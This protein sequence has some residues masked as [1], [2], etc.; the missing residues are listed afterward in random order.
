VP[1]PGIPSR[2]ITTFWGQA[3]LGDKTV[4]NIDCRSFS[5]IRMVAIQSCSD[6]FLPP[7]F[8]GPS[9]EKRF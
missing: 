6:E 3:I 9:L 5:L 1:D 2:S 4:M 7:Q 8:C